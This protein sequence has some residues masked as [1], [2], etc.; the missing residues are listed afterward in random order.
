MSAAWVFVGT[1]ATQMARRRHSRVWRFPLASL[2]ALAA[3]CGGGDDGTGPEPPNGNTVASVTVS[4]GSATIDIGSTL[5]LSATPRDASG[6]TISGKS[7]SWSS[8]TSAVAT[9]SGSGLVTGVT[10][11]AATITASTDGKSGSAQVTV[12]AAVNPEVVAS[13][14]IGPAG[15]TLSSDAVGLTVHAGALTDQRTLEVRV[16]DQSSLPFADYS[17]APQFRLE[18]FPTDRA[19]EVDVRLK[20]TA[21]LDGVS[22]IAYGTAVNVSTD[23]MDVEVQRLSYRMYPAR[24]SSGW[25]V[26]TVTVHGK[27]AAAAQVR[28][29]AAAIAAADEFP[30]LLDG[31]LTAVKSA[32]T[33]KTA[34]FLAMSYGAP[35]AQLQ[36]LLAQYAQYME[37]AYATVI[38]AG[39]NYNYRK[40]WPVA[41]SVFPFAED[42]GTYGQFCRP[43]EVYPV[44][45]EHGYFEFNSLRTDVMNEWPATA[46]HEFFHFTQA[47]YVVGAGAPRELDFKWLKEATSTWIEEKAPSNVLSFKNR[48]FLSYRDSIFN[49]FHSGLNAKAGY[50]RSA[51]VKYA[52]DRWGDG[53]VKQAFSAY[54]AGGATTASFLGALP[55]GTTTWWPEFLVAYFG[56]QV[57]SLGQD[58]LPPKAAI[59]FAAYPGFSGTNLSNAA[60]ASARFINLVIPPDK[61]GTGTDV[62]FRLSGADSAFF[63]LL[64]FQA[65]TSGSWTKVK[66]SADSVVIPAAM[67]KEG[68][69]LLIAAIRPDATAP[70]TDRKNT[71]INMNM[72]LADGDWIASGI[73]AIDDQIVYNRTEAG[74]E[75]KVDVAEHVTE[76]MEFIASN[77]AFKRS[78]D[79]SRWT[80]TAKPGVEDALKGYGLVAGA[81]LELVPNAGGSYVL[82]ANFSMGAAAPH[83][84]G[85]GFLWLLLPVPFLL[86]LG[87]RRTRR[88]AGVLAALAGASL[89]ACDLG[90]ISFAMTARYEFQL[91]MASV[92]YTADAADQAVALVTYEDVAGKMMLDSYRSE[93]WSYTRNELG[94]KIDSVS[95]VRTGAGVATFTYDG[96]LYLDDHYPQEPEEPGARYA[97]LAQLPAA[98]VREAAARRGIRL[99]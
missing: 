80:W 46:I 27:P 2:L 69:R 9:V 85:A 12:R 70:Y 4:P 77:G 58:E 98:A 90:S 32:D 56:N 52:A 17:A 6:A 68:R 19:V 30:T 62:T 83:P 64:V 20:A 79:F 28:S 78:A 3:A 13:G 14:V 8:Q 47:Q 1:T 26:A 16:N 55:E 43:G 95:H 24:D 75:N 97:G 57:Y 40:E 67:V 18:G 7:I 96:R 53:I 34:H 61:I 48:F 82:K 88:F 93:Y 39:Y 60:G 37:E 10:A 5:Q 76:V 11:G 21:P 51:I 74:D 31:Y 66:E 42:P 33:V 38:A 44:D 15:G 59:N 92:Q 63:R 22:L 41:V 36:P 35:R 71:R 86:P 50:G 84:S 73:E 87:K 72:G 49:G 89:W 81:T 91:P 54:D 65:N 25:L 99:P 94:E 23:G 29:G 45:S